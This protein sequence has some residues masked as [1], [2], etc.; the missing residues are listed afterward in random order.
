MD[1]NRRGESKS[2]P[3][4]PLESTRNRTRNAKGDKPGKA[5]P[6][7]AKT[8]AKVAD[9]KR[10]TQMREDAE[11]LYTRWRSVNTQYHQAVWGY[12]EAVTGFT[13]GD[14]IKVEIKGKTSSTDWKIMDCVRAHGENEFKLLM[15]PLKLSGE[16]AKAYH[17]VLSR[18]VQ[19]V[20]VSSF[21]KLKATMTDTVIMAKPLPHPPQRVNKK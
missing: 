2:R 3:I 20:A 6:Q 7:P 19:R 13:K 15:Q 8:Q 18:P 21:P 9:K 4:G 10:Q 14:V 16:G 1:K 5:R 17:R 11:H 12:V